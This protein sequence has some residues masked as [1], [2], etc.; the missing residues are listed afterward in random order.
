MTRVRDASSFSGYHLCRSKLFHY[1]LHSGL[2]FF[3]QVF[4]FTYIHSG[5]IFLIDTVHR[6]RIKI[7]E[8]TRNFQKRNVHIE[9]LNNTFFRTCRSHSAILPKFNFLMMYARYLGDYTQILPTL[10][11]KKNCDEETDDG[12]IL[13]WQLTLKLPSFY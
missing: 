11:D 3:L 1:L 8:I 12:K 9:I 13:G 7:C 5:D 10:E 2:F 6:R 4:K